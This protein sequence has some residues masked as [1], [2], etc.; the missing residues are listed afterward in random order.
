MRGTLARLLTV[1]ALVA[2]TAAVPTAAHAIGDNGSCKRLYGINDAWAQAC[3]DYWSVGGGRYD[4]WVRID[5]NNRYV[6]ASFDGIVY[7]LYGPGAY[8]TEQFV[9]ART[10]YVRVCYYSNGTGCGAWW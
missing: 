2:A 5:I 7:N 8:G 6:Q 10:Y 1:F 9:S 4:G 3:G